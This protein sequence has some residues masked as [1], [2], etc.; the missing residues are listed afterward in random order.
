MNIDVDGD[1]TGDIKGTKA[2]TFVVIDKNG[3]AKVYT[4]IKN[5][6]EIAN[7]ASVY[8]VRTG[9]GTGYA[10]LVAIDLGATGASKGGATSGDV[11]FVYK[12]SFAATGTDN[13]EN[14]YYTYKTLK[15]GEDTKVKFDDQYD[16]VT[17]MTT[18]PTLLV[19]VEY[20]ESGYVTDATEIAGGSYAFGVDDDYSVQAGGAVTLK[21]DVLTVGGNGYYMADNCKVYLLDTSA[22]TCKLS[23]AKKV[24]ALGSVTTIWGI[25]DANGEYTTLFVDD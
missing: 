25:M 24:A 14:V 18:A 13:D 1:G 10:K 20:D 17:K 9:A 15:N 11:I 2:T 23:T 19:D 5:V 8:V 12:T 3:D 7:P 4:G 21:G 6:P 22:G 16:G